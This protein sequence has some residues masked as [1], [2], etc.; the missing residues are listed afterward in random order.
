MKL[1][2]K[3]IIMYRKKN[4]KV[5]KPLIPNPETISAIQ[6]AQAGRLETVGNSNNLLT[7]LHDD[8]DPRVV[9]KYIF[10]VDKKIAFTKW[11]IN[12]FIQWDAPQKYTLLKR[13]CISALK[14]RLDLLRTHK[15][16]QEANAVS[17]LK[18]KKAIRSA[19]NELQ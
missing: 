3:P 10:F 6:D 14:E 13:H 19:R 8:I 2:N 17:S 5:I 15:K 11:R 4:N 9:I 7:Y 12:K 18:L 16:K 1:N